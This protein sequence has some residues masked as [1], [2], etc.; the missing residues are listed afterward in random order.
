MN[1]VRFAWRKLPFC[2]FLAALLGTSG[3]WAQTGWN[4]ALKKSVFARDDLSKLQAGQVLG[5]RSTID[6]LASVM[7]VQNCF[8]VAKAPDQVAAALLKWNPV[9]HPE[10]GIML[11]E[12]VERPP[13]PKNFSRLALDPSQSRAKA[14]IDKSMRQ[15]QGGGPL[16]LSK[17]ESAQLQAANSGPNSLSTAWR[18][19]L[20]ARAANY[21]AAG[22]TQAPPYENGASKTS[23]SAQI[24]GLVKE[25]P[26]ITQNFAGLLGVAFNNPGAEKQGEACYWEFLQ[27]QREGTLLLGAVTQV[28]DPSGNGKVQVADFQYYVSNS[29]SSALILYDLI[30]VEV[31]GRPA[32]LVWRSDFVF[33]PSAVSGSGMERMATENILLLEVQKSIKCFLKDLS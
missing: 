8:L 16:N 27:V 3:A 17:A 6:Q 28:N 15:T 24:Q 2:I 21:Q 14:L 19:I 31:Q 20:M 11:H 9:S 30:P 33:I 1:I 23:L 25:I 29:F 32:T 12:S 26:G 18:D 13:V 4:E 7:S 5:K 22:I 10:L